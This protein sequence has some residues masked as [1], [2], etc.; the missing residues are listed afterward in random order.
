MLLTYLPH[1]LSYTDQDH[2]PKG[3]PAHTELILPISII[4]HEN[5]AQTC[6]Q[7]S[8][9][10]AFSQQPLI[11]PGELVCIKLTTTNQHRQRVQ[12]DPWDIAHVVMP[13]KAM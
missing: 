3:C 9:T 4:N 5:V 6:F 2:M 11:C 1:M 12:G 10:E 7:S 13:L 8:L